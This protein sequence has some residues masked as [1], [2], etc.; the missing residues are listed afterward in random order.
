MRNN[1]SA[2]FLTNFIVGLLFFAVFPGGASGQDNSN[3][4]KARE[5]NNRAVA[6]VGEKKYDEAIG[7]LEEA[8]RLKPEYADAYMNLGSA[9]MLAGRAEKGAELLKH[10]IEL[11]PKC[12]KARNQLGVTYEKLG[13]YDLA[14]E[15]LKKSVELNPDYA[16]GNFNLGAT[17]LWAGKSKLAEEYLAKAE[18]LDPYKTEVKR[19]QAVLYAKKGRYTDAIAKMRDVMK[20]TPDDEE[21]N[22]ILCKIYLMANDR[23]SALNMYQSFK[24]V[25][26]PVA[27]QMFKWIFADKLVF[28]NDQ[29]P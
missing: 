18:K 15:S 16:L 9:H 26:Q 8:A 1:S 24:A 12:P 19:Y 22:L 29:R 27:D 3:S 21:A 17:Y 6:L 28:A 14:I 5:L 4:A 7:L 25:N 2:A 13:K 11:D 20:I 10:S 23:Q